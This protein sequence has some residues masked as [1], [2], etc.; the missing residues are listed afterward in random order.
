M[1]RLL[2]LPNQEPP[3]LVMVQSK[4]L[5]R[6]RFGPLAIGRFDRSEIFAPAAD[7]DDAPASQIGGLFGIRRDTRA[8]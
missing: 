4:L 6:H 5:D 3:T 1:G 7:D 2:P 8:R